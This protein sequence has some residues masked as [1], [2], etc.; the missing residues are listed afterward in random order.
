MTAWFFMVIVFL[1]V[2][3]FAVIVVMVTIVINYIVDSVGFG[4]SFPVITV[5]V[6]CLVWVGIIIIFVCVFGIDR[7]GR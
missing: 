4:V 6:C 3:V 2:S 1:V 7:A 5:D